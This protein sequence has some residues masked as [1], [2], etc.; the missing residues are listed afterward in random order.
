MRCLTAF[1]V[2]L[3]ESPRWDPRRG[4]IWFVDLFRGTLHA[5]DPNGE[6]RH[7]A[8]F[9]EELCSIALADEGSLALLLRSGLYRYSPET[10]AAAAVAAAPYDP[11][12]HLFNDCGVDPSGNLW[13]GIAAEDESPGA[14]ALTRWTP[15]DGFELVSD[16][17]TLPNGI[18]W[19]RSGDERFVV[20]SLDRRI[21][22][23]RADGRA[24]RWHVP[25][26]FGLPDGLTVDADGHL[27]IAY[28]GGACV[29]RHRADGALLEEHQ[30]P[31]D[32]AT[33]P[34]L[35]PGTDR[36][37]L[38][39]TTARVDGTAIRRPPA[40]QVHV[41]GVTAQPG[42]QPWLRWTSP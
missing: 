37:Q 3:G 11:A 22:T 27:W 24:D 25:E 17:M 38:V 33:A 1:A 21:T 35:V 26:H 42:P 15:R 34:L 40:G 9:G 7:R 4:C 16:G 6:Q 19:S 5:V 28:W 39:V 36:T 13:V 8:T 32:L 20:D 18:A 10:H 23:Y 12:T 41:A 2:D 30:L 31:V 14:G 29:R